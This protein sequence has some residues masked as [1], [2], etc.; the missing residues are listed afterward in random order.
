[1]STSSSFHW[2][3][4]ASVHITSRMSAQGS[5]SASAM[6]VQP[7]SYRGP[8]VSRRWTGPAKGNHSH[9][10]IQ[11][12][13]LPSAGM[14]WCADFRRRTRNETRWNLHETH[15]SDNCDQLLRQHATQ[16]QAG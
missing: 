8:A 13:N 2:L 7:S 14:R 5:A 12:R 4:S 3:F 15:T 9:R 16:E 10:R 1:M 11:C 6:A